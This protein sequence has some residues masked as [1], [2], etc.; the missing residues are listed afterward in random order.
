MPKHKIDRPHRITVFLSK[1]ER[2][3]LYILQGQVWHR[4]V[5][6]AIRF[7]IASELKHLGFAEQALKIFNEEEN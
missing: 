5:S 3:G 1:P 7:L 6:D 2:D 4:N